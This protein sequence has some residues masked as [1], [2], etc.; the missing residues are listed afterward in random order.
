MRSL[1]FP[2]H[3][4]TLW[5]MFYWLPFYFIFLGKRSNGT[6]Q[7][8]MNFFQRFFGGHGYF[9]RFFEFHDI[10]MKIPAKVILNYSKAFNYNSLSSQDRVARDY[11]KRKFWVRFP[12]LQILVSSLVSEL[13]CNEKLKFFESFFFNYKFLTKNVSKIWS[14]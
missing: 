1:F 9:E 13:V 6:C 8:E 11:L 2:F 10:F 5:L 4:G 3:L 12:I 7:W 14:F